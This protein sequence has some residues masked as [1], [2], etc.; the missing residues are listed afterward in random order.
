MDSKS[1]WKLARTFFS[2]IDLD[3]Y[4]LWD[5]KSGR[6]NGVFFPQVLYNHLGELLG[7]I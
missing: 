4:F 6:G 2:D 5:E 3:S 7:G 1:E